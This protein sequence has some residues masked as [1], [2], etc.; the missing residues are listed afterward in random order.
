MGLHHWGCCSYSGFVL[1]RLESSFCHFHVQV[2]PRTA[3]MQIV[4]SPA[5]DRGGRGGSVPG[6]AWLSV[7]PPCLTSMEWFAALFPILLGAMLAPF[8]MQT[9]LP[10]V[11]ALK[12]SVEYVVGRSG[13]LGGGTHQPKM[14]IPYPACWMEMTTPGGGLCGRKSKKCCFLQFFCFSQA[15]WKMPYSP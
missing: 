15:V 2:F 14:H 6:G 8:W 12:A 9:A 5:A 7:R 10:S 1:D 11:A 4:D 13:G 3:H